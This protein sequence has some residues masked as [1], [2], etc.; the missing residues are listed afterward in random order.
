VDLNADVTTLNDVIF[1][2]VVTITG[3]TH[4]I[5]STNG[6]IDLNAA[7]NSE[8]LNNYGINLTANN[9]T[10]Y[11]QTIGI[12]QRVGALVISADAARLDGNI[13]ALSVDTT[14][15][16]LTTL[17]AGTVDIDTVGGTTVNLGALAGNNLTIS[18]GTSVTLADANIASLVI[19][20]ATNVNF[21]GNFVTSG[22]VTVG[23]ANIAGSISV[24]STGSI[25]A[26]D[27][28]ILD[29]K[30]GA[31]NGHIIIDGDVSTAG[32]STI[33]I[34]SDDYVYIALNDDAAITAVNGGIT[35]NANSKV[36]LGPTGNVGVIATSGTGLI[37]IIINDTGAINRLIMGT[38]SGTKISGG[39]TVDI[40]GRSTIANL[41]EGDGNVEFH[42]TMRLAADTI[43][44]SN[45]GNVT[46]DGSINFPHVL[47]VNAAN[48]TATF[49]SA[50][51]NLSTLTA[52][53]VNAADTIFDA[54]VNVAAGGLTVNGSGATTTL[55]TGTTITS[56][57]DVDINDSVVL[58]GGVGTVTIDTSAAN[59]SIDILGTINATTANTESL[60]LTSGTGN[61]TLRSD[62]GDLKTLNTLTILSTGQ[63]ELNGAIDAG[64]DIL[65][66]GATNVVLGSNVGL[67]AGND[68]TLY[69]VNGVFA[70]AAVAGH[71]ITINALGGI[72]TTTTQAPTSVTLT[73]GDIVNVNGPI[74][75]TGQV[76][77]TGS[78]AAADDIALAANVIGTS[79]V[80]NNGTA[81]ITN[82]TAAQS[83]TSGSTTFNGLVTMGADVSALGTV[84]FN[85]AVTLTGGAVT[86]TINSTDGDIDLNAAVNSTAGESLTLTAGNGTVY[87]QAIGTGVGGRVGDLI[88]TGDAA[89]LNGDIAAVSVDTTGVGLT[90]LTKATVDI[91]TLGGNF[92]TLGP[93]TG[94]NNLTIHAGTTVDLVDADIA[95]LVIDAATTVDFNGNFVTSG[96][97]RV[98]TAI[99]DA[100]TVF[101]T[102]SIQAGG[103]VTLANTAGGI[104]INGP[105]T[106]TGAVAMTAANNTTGNV[107]INADVSATDAININA[108]NNITVDAN[109]TGNGSKA[110]NLTADSDTSGAGN[111]VIAGTTAD[112][113]ITTAGNITLTGEDVTIGVGGFVGKVVTTGTGNIT[114][115][116]DKNDDDTSGS[117]T[118]AT[119]G[120]MIS[121]N[122]DI[123]VI[124]AYDVN[125]GGTGMFANGNISIVGAAPGDGIDHNI[126]IST[127]VEA[128]TGGNITMTAGNSV[129]FDN[130][131]AEVR[132]TDE[133][134]VTITATAGNILE[135]IADAT[136]DIAGYQ[137][138]LSAL[139]GRIGEDTGAPGLDAALE[140][141]SRD[142]ISA[143]TA[144]GH[145]DIWLAET[146]GPMYVN[147]I[148]TGSTAL[149]TVTLQALDTAATQITNGMIEDAQIVSPQITAGWLRLNATRGIGIE[150]TLN[151][152]V[153]V[154]AAKIDGVANEYGIY[155]QNDISLT[156]GT[157]NSLSGVTIVDPGDLNDQD[158]IEIRTT[159]AASSLTVSQPV[160]NNDAG[161]ITLA[162][163]GT[164]DAND[165]IIND[166]VSSAG[167]NGSIS[168]YAGDSI[169]QGA[170]ADV[171]AAGSG[172]ISY[173]AGRDYNN[174]TPRAGLSTGLSD[175]T[176]TSGAT[177]TSTSGN[178]SMY[179]P[180]DIKL[181]V[182]NTT[183]NAYITANDSTYITPTDSIGAIIDNLSGGGENITANTAT[184][185]AATGIGSTDDINTEVTNVNALNTNTGNI[186]I[187]EVTSGGDL[188]VT[189]AIQSGAGGGNINIQTKDGTLTVSSTGVS[190]VAGAGT[191]TLIAGDAGL[192]YDNN[193]AI[194]APV[195]SNSGTV[196]LTSAGNDVTFSAAGDVTTTSGTVIVSAV[197]GLLGGQGKITMADGAVI[198][199]GNAQ[200]DMDAY[201]DITLGCVRTTYAADDAITITSAAGGIID[202][203]DT[204]VD[205]I[206]N[207]ASA[208]V[209]LDAATGIGTD[210]ALETS[211]YNLQANNTVS[212]DI[213]IA[214]TD[215]INLV[216]VIDN[217]AGGDINITAGGD[218]TTTIVTAGGSVTL[219][220]TAGNLADTAGVALVT[221]GST[222]TLK[223]SG[224]I[225]TIDNPY[226]VKITGTLWVWTASHQDEVSVNLVGTV[227][228]GA[229]T[230][231]CEILTPSP[232]GLV[233]LNNHLMG[234]GNYGSGST[235][236]SILSRGYGYVVITRADMFTSIY[237][238]ALQPW[239]YK[240]M[241]PWVLSEGAKIDSD[242]L[243]AVPAVI[244]V[245][246]LNLPALQT[247]MQKTANYYVIRSLK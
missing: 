19:D 63:T 222:S 59:K 23:G 105:V 147:R 116:A 211:I 117:F 78:L 129:L 60:T 39:G 159:G 52:L 92:V 107:A 134:N 138:T 76:N 201:G 177:A 171:T 233:I 213:R 57:G 42:D 151:T 200:T 179:A 7:V 100:I 188:N 163:E 41:V 45:N 118:L 18:A 84:T 56:A 178:I 231:R 48:G 176:M 108:D 71:D 74:T 246:Q 27:N 162:A 5:I 245:S 181:S 72:G 64:T 228:S 195:T 12:G 62:I 50:I 98:D 33:A 241:L 70:L 83:N 145:G 65:L 8:L 209:D 136:V 214:E 203:G 120:S 205:I 169:T 235:N 53:T 208:T 85:G 143:T 79:V 189:G 49:S 154:L 185:Q 91:D 24:A 110:I 135:T 17:T 6:N 133:G 197:S 166:D 137:I 164:K 113:T 109:I 126:T 155:I 32:S 196:T 127:S 11:A 140:I 192:S 31:N 121:S 73:A 182:L 86:R 25:Q 2:D 142:W 217:V 58:A 206:A 30:T 55:T 128:L 68:I 106:S 153:S 124:N 141:D 81:G 43:V 230:E 101:A 229:Y 191:I 44:A 180:R 36:A 21:N 40:E 15:V 38:A 212:G 97:V 99:T 89:Q 130:A 198:N 34:S 131:A 240:M 61:V 95:S 207:T 221:A 170:T 202:G 226:D 149:G 220:A 102:G 232:P 93:L 223:A 122:K 187:H 37:D 87:T 236:G 123:N 28:I 46:F 3:A 156:I 104:T 215:A 184:L 119:T 22:I 82:V 225:G 111:L 10:V 54:N 150:D 168:L 125:I 115:V 4:T 90:T 94:A 16:G 146:L 114:I 216:S 227:D 88:I 1:N 193:L 219:Y 66:D 14:A 103:N 175:I 139:N 204:D 144:T 194:N 67:T 13:Q 190:T 183:G 237:E 224:I 160:T 244:D 51:G 174:G 218:I 239:G 20:D 157:A 165:L 234:G 158:T 77:I 75:S 35:I 47:T 9:G 186:N 80:F 247:E 210:N 242:F 199:S 167:G 29:T 161:S 69:A 238:R 26:G 132:T 173:Y 148:T 112:S 243:S 152:D 172:S 96:A